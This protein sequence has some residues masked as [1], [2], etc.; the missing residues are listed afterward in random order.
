MPAFRLQDLMLIRH[1]AIVPQNVNSVIVLYEKG[2]DQ[3]N[4]HHINRHGAYL[5]PFFFSEN[6]SNQ[7]F[8]RFLF[9]IIP[10]SS[11]PLVQIFF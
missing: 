8:E 1:F 11:F 6:M 4:T 9:L 2:A 10:F 3:K 5:H 7:R